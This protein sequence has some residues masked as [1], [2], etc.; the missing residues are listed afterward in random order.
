V[1]ETSLPPYSG[2]DAKCVKCW[3]TGATT[4]YVAGGADRQ[5][6]PYEW[7]HRACRNCGYQWDEAVLGKEEQTP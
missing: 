1:T 3:A 4:E 5:W 6:G 2:D 7:L